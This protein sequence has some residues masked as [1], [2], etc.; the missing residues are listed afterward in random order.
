MEKMTIDTG[1]VSIEFLSAAGLAADISALSLF[2][3]HDCSGICKVNGIFIRGNRM[4]A[5]QF[6]D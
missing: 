6:W 2:K 5:D 1:V 3:S 4:I